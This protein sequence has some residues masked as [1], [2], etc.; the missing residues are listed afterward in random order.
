MADMH[1]IVPLDCRIWLE[2]QVLPPEFCK[3]RSRVWVPGCSA[4]GWRVQWCTGRAHRSNRCTARHSG[5]NRRKHTV[6]CTF[7]HR[8]GTGRS[9]VMAPPI[10]N[11]NIGWWWRVSFTLLQ[12]H[13]R[14][15]GRQAGGGG[16]SVPVWK[17]GKKEK[18]RACAWIRKTISRSS[19]SYSD[20]TS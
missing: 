14:G 11:L 4:P 1:A 2:F 5:K 20:W 7:A 9:G 10:L 17:S 19:N 3:S 16:G 12:L 15:N 6:L 13:C 8:E 18:P